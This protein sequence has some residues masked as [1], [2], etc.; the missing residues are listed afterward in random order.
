M[1][2]LLLS[3]LC[4]PQSV[5]VTSPP[6]RSQDELTTPTATRRLT[7]LAN[8]LLPAFFS[9]YPWLA[10]ERRFTQPDP[11][12]F[13]RY[14]TGGYLAWRN[15]LSRLRVELNAISPH[16]LD[17]AGWTAFG[18]SSA[19]ILT[20]ELLVNSRS[21]E[22]WDA[23]SY[24]TRVEKML[25]SLRE[26]DY[27]PI[28]TRLMRTILLLEGLPAY[29][30]GAR[31]SLVSP[32]RVWKNEAVARLVDLGVS[33]EAELPRS[34]SKLHLDRRE[35]KRFEVALNKALESTDKFRSW[36]LDKR[37]PR[38]D[39]AGIMGA[40]NWEGL[41]QTVSGSEITA[42]RLKTLLLRDIAGLNRRWG[43][44][45]EQK[46]PGRAPLAPQHLVKAIRTSSQLAASLAERAGLFSTSEDSNLSIR[47]KGDRSTP[48]QFAQLWPDK[49]IGYALHLEI[50][51]P[52][53]SPDIMSTRATQLNQRALAVLGIRYGW[54]GESKLRGAAS[55]AQNPIARFLWN[56]SVF[57]GWG[58]YALDWITRIDWVENPFVEDTRL[59][60]EIARAW[61]LEATRLLASI[62]IHVE[63]L[64]VPAAAAALR[65]R[66]SFDPETALLEAR[67][68][69][70]DPLR[71]IGYLGLLEMRLLEE[72]IGREITGREA[73]Q[74]TLATILANPHLRPFDVRTRLGGLRPR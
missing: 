62:E 7:L 15:Q 66:S 37:A 65:R 71:G 54:T 68:A 14:G 41:M 70:H 17:E 20:Q 31:T 8:E 2:P 42:G 61:M 21:L 3:V 36:L 30:E 18:A 27:V 34:F 51:S 28:R 32:A 60:I 10:Y 49:Q 9:R 48:R 46:T 29:W 56:R 43:K 45:W 35:T 47:I 67:M 23:T 58:L 1:L 50:G 25:F 13:A 19:W 33:I 24:V 64:S 69:H 26:S 55:R 73:L 16:E 40:A 5:R 52:L 12:A 38:G 22:R 72:E 57:E 4:I 74:E 63:G 11:V 39:E 6:E 59:E 44:N 53:W